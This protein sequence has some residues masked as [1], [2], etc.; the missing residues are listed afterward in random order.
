MNGD[1]KVDFDDWQ[2]FFKPGSRNIDERSAD[3][4]ESIFIKIRRKI[5]DSWLSGSEYRDAFE[6]EQDR[7]FNGVISIGDFKRALR[8]LNLKV[9]NSEMRQAS[10]EFDYDDDGQ[11]HYQPFL[12]RIAPSRRRSKLTIGANVQRS[13]DKLRSMI[14]SRARSHGGNLR[15]PF[16]HFARQGRSF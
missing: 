6:K 5:R 16:K 7:D 9:S 11:M 4:V 15:D 8:Q 13:A 1:G 14:R 12:R 2:D 10:E 3:S